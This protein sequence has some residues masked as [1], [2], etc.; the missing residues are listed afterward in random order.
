MKKYDYSEKTASEYAKE[1]SQSIV[2]RYQRNGYTEDKRRK[3]NKTESRQV[4]KAIAAA[5]IAIRN[6]YNEDSAKATAEFFII[7]NS[8]ETHINSY[9]S[10]YIPINNFLKA[11]IHNI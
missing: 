1:I 10:V 6:G 3:A 8:G 5:L 4:E 9:D 11:Y 2:I 7:H